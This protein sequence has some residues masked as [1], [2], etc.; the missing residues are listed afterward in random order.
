MNVAVSPERGRR[1]G[2]TMEHPR[3]RA[4][5]EEQRSRRSLSGET[6]RAEVFL[7]LFFVAPQLQ[8]HQ[9]MRLRRS[10]NKSKNPLSGGVHS[11]LTG[12]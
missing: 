6:L 7:N 11:L 1:Q 4:V 12:C 2:V 10:S 5:T 8:T 3:Q 9:G